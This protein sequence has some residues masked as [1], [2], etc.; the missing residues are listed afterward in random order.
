MHYESNYQ[1][2]AR[3]WRPK[4]FSELVG[5]DATVR[6]LKNA[7]EG[8]RLA[9]A[10]LLI[11]ARGTGKTTTARLI[12][13]AINYDT[14][15]QFEIDQ[16]TPL[17]QS[18]LDGTCMDVIEIDG[19]S[20]NSVDH[21]RD[22][23][24][25]CVY[26]PTQCRYKVI[27]IDE[28][29]ALS[30]AAFN[31]LLKIVEEPPAHVKF[32]FATTEPH[33]VHPPIVSRCQRFEFRPIQPAIIQAQLA[34]ITQAENI[35]TEPDALAAI[36]RLAAGGMRDAQSILDQM[37]AFCTGK[38]TE[39]DVTEVYGLVPA[40][41]LKVLF[42]AMVQVE[43]QQ[44]LKMAHVWQSENKDLVRILIDVQSIIKETLVR[45]ISNATLDVG[46]S[47]EGLM[48]MLEVLHD[49]E[50]L[51]QK[52]FSDKVSLDITLLKAAEYGRS[53]SIDTLI[54]SLY[55]LAQTASQPIQPEVPIVN[56][57]R[58]AEIPVKQTSQASLV[59]ESIEQP[60]PSEPKA[61]HMEG[62]EVPAAVEHLPKSTRDLL[63]KHLRAQYTE[64]NKV[65]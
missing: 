24:E 3:R 60:D 2:I 6:T 26:L 31:A 44:I 61:I 49:G 54:Q 12:A 27:I 36:A 39:A 32:I 47:I 63:E 50:L 33:K 56:K 35:S 58:P 37:I 29:H 21:V 59:S 20:N 16:E 14:G 18:I 43:Y 4:N 45:K 1:V 55:K 52:G 15:P 57:L 28:V 62:F 17:T 42:E 11:G 8:N 10:Y 22:L 48:R 13:K 23:R 46:I 34:K 40:A 25:N 5:Q 30:T 38:I 53:R 19:A 64:L 9:H 51:I 41:A 7:I 65:K